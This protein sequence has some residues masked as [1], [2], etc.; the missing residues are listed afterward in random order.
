MKERNINKNITR[1][2]IFSI[3]IIFLTSS[4]NSALTQTGSTQE[5]VAP[6]LD[7]FDDYFEWRDDF[8]NEQKIDMTKSWGYLVEGGEVEM[9]NTFNVWTDPAWE[10]LV[11][12]TVNNN[13]GSLND[14]ALNF[15]VSYDS[16][17]QNDYD[18]VRFKHENAPGVFLDYWLESYDS[19]E[20]SFWVRVPNLGS[21]SNNMYMFYGNPSAT[22]QSDFGDVFTDW[23]EEW[24]NDKQ[25]TYHADTEGGW[26][27][28][29]AYGS[30]QFLVAWEEGQAYWPSAGSFGFKQEIRASMYSPSGGD[31]TVFDKR[32]FSDVDDGWTYFRNEDPSV[33][34]GSGGKFA[35]AW[36]HWAPTNAPFD[37]Q[38]ITTM[39]IYARTVQK[40][41]SSFQLG[42]VKTI[43]SESNC[44]ADP[45]VQYDSENDK[46]MV[47]WED[48]RA[49]T[50][51]YDIYARL[52]NS[53]LGTSGSEKQIT[54]DTDTQTEPYAAYDPNNEQYFIV[55]EDGIHPSD[56]PFRIRGGIFDEN[57]N[58]ISTFTVAEPSGWPSNS[59]DYFFPSV[60]Y[61]SDS[62][63][64]LVTWNCGD[65][66][67]SPKDWYG[68]IMGKI[69]DDSGGVEV[70]EFTIKSGEFIRTDIVPY[71]SEAF[72]VSYDNENKVYGR[73]V[74]AEG[75]IYGSDVQLSTSP[76]AQGDWANLATDGSKIF[77][78]WEDL[79]LNYPD[80]FDDVYP[81]AF[82]N[83]IN[84]NIPDGSDITITFGQ[85]KEIVLEA[86]VTS[87]QIEPPNL[88]TWHQFLVGY[89][90]S[91]TFDILD[92]SANTK[93]IENADDG[94][95][96]SII[97]PN[98]YPIIRLQAH[99]SR[100]I[101]NDSPTLDWWSVLYEGADE[102][103]PV[104]TVDS[105]DGVQGLDPWYISECVTI[106]LK[107]VDYPEDTGSGV[108]YT[109]YTIDGG[110]PQIYD[111]GSGIHVCA[112]E[113][114]WYGNWEVNFW[115]VDYKGN[116][117]SKN[118][119][120]NFRTI[121]IDARRPEV[122]II[123]PTEEAEV[124]TPFLVRAD[125][126]DNAEVEKVTFDIEP[127][128]QRP[129]LP[130]VDTSPPYEWLCDEKPISRAKAIEDDP[131]RS[132]VMVQ[133]RASAYDASGQYW[134]HEVFIQVTNWN[135]AR[136]RIVI[137]NFKLLLEKL[138]L[139]LAV[140]DALR[141]DLSKPDNIDSVEFTAKKV[142]SNKEYSI[143]DDD[144][145]D[146]ISASFDIPTGLYKISA[147]TYNSGVEKSTRLISWVFFINR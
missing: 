38:P 112:Y 42:T 36:E 65:L 27:P 1:L 140:D 129:G 139:G 59:V 80:P 60:E 44:Q 138:M 29:V 2:V 97:D 30:N 92:A 96:L 67:Q 132:G 71:L 83:M 119:P 90:G 34:Y 84:L 20:A 105:I 46:Y 120:E 107:A 101:P 24:A 78:A 64:Y 70:S 94:E 127:F 110:S 142:L 79:R 93:I 53:N 141:I 103:P 8:N 6:L 40:S 56:G 87:K 68:N 39:D 61:D 23:D 95:D 118:K 145:S 113:P 33:A 25:I 51:D 16:D 58:T 32:I 73:L 122:W 134:I 4:A 146:G 43:C 81:D 35:V 76:S 104:T 14:Y 82:G 144:F 123:E 98:Q 133:V 49:T 47:V 126:T 91:I 125:A 66:S 131:Q 48:A 52:F 21:G 31:P 45:Y 88:E 13:G 17:M 99:F 10:K 128:G 116:V 37:P 5:P 137:H 147:K 50:G 22:S 15:V 11:P 75:D 115:S 102:E 55:W 41:G 72:F 121:Y 136:E 74:S 19:S 12:V 69:F 114:N 57:L 18:D 63:R 9:K 117:E 108:R 135:N 124:Q 62:E 100:S 3:L 26:D 86:Q 106:W 77:V 89:D 130:Y 85:E 54:S 111:V 28:D 109:Y 7:P 143:I